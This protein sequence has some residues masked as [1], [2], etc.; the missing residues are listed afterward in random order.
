MVVCSRCA[1]IYAGL[2]VG[3]LIPRRPKP[4]TA[5]TGLLL[6]LG[7]NAG[8]WVAGWM[9]AGVVHPWRL[10]LGAG[11]GWIAAAWLLG[12]LRARSIAG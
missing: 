1:G 11:L 9:G 10:L 2:L 6:A 3:S 12:S 5:K 7:L 4:A 8:D